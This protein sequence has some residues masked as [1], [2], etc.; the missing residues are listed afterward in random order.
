MT[1]GEDGQIKIS[2]PVLIAILSAALAV[3]SGGAWF[4]GAK[5]S[6]TAEASAAELA[7]VQKS[8]EEHHRSDE[9][10]DAVAASKVAT[11][12]ARLDRIEAKLDRLLARR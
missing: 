5:P 7:A 6:I 9:A 3:G 12:E 1:R 4:A 10:R 8:V 11:V 2:M